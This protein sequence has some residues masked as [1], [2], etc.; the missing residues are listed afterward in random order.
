M[1]LPPHEQAEPRADPGEARFA[2]Q[3]ALQLLDGL[4]VDIQA[5]DGLLQQVLHRLTDLGGNG[6]E[7]E[8]QHEVISWVVGSVALAGLME[9]GRRLRRRR[10]LSLTVEADWL[11]WIDLDGPSSELLL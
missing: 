7:S 8:G 10:T 11:G 3:S 5:L 9:V 4:P 2:P 1:E 6:S